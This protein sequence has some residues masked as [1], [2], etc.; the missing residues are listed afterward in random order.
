MEYARSGVEELWIVDPERKR[1]DVRRFAESADEP[2]RRVGPRQRLSSRLLP[3][4]Q[5]SMAD[6]FRR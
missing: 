4:L 6:V 1:V 2:V 3:G 5:I